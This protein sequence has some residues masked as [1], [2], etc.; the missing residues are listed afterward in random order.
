[1]PKAVKIF[2]R[3]V[4][5][6]NKVVGKFSMYLVFVMIGV[7]LFESISRTIFDKP[8]IWVVE[9]AQFTMAAY[10]LLGGGY[11]MILKGHV[12][13][14]LLYGRWSDKTKATVDAFT[15]L[16]LIFYLVFLLL[17]AYSS[18]E[19]AVMYGQRNRS[20]WAPLMAPIKIIMGTGILLMLLQAI[21]TW[22]KD[23][24]KVRGEKI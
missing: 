21:A 22:F 11:S 16:F 24:A 4:D 13:M 14:D 18:I 10:Y 23:L 17:G 3:Y 7:L 8:H 6:V 5:A 20:A 2:V 19:Y 9:V 12:R 1:M 15:G